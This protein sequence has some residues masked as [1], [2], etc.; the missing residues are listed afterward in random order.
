MAVRDSL[1]LLSTYP[2][3][4]PNSVIDESVAFT[5][6][7]GARISDL[8]GGVRIQVRRDDSQFAHLLLPR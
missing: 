1:L 4:T 2:E 5:V 3:P 6:A 7:L 8:A